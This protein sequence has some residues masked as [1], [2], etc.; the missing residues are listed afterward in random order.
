MSAPPQSAHRSDF[1]DLKTLE[2]EEQT[3]D[4]TDWLFKSA[5]TDKLQ[6]R[7]LSN[8]PFEY[9]DSKLRFIVKNTLNR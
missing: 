5:V 1:Y 4:P 8:E 6:Y 2:V 9:F 3:L 7:L